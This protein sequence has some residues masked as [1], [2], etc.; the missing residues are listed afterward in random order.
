MVDLAA[1][2]TKEA[3]HVKDRPGIRNRDFTAEYFRK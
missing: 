2:S 1:E 3:G